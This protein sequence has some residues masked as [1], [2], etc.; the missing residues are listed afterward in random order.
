MST[1]PVA[2]PAFS[3]DPAELRSVGAR[4]T[5]VGMSGRGLRP[6]AL[7][8]A[9]PQVDAAVG[10][11]VQTWVPAIDAWTRSLTTL[12]GAVTRAADLIGTT[13]TEQAASWS[14][15]PAPTTGPLP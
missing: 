1:P 11:L 6:P 4:L 13:D 3:A 14:A 15:V 2:S 8:G 10:A 7:S 5:S 12:G 9:D